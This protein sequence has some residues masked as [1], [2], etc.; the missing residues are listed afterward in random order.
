VEV[1]LVACRLF[2]GRTHQIRVHMRSIGHPVVG[3]HRYGGYRQSLESP[4]LFLHAATLGFD[5]PITA[6]PM[7]FDSPLPPDLAA[8]LDR[9]T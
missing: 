9:L 4:R 2:T 5:H 8:V 7:R 6:A 1:T 3:D